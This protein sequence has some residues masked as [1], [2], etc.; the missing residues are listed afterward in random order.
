MKK[1]EN[2]KSGFPFTVDVR[3]YLSTSKIIKNNL[4]KPNDTGND[5]L[6]IK[7]IERSENKNAF[8]LFAHIL[9]G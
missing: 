6:L 9:E 3:D 5:L 4:N 2:E 1:K 8:D 7:G